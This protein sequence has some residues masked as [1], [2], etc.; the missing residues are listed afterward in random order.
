MTLATHIAAP[1]SLGSLEQDEGNTSQTHH[2]IKM[3]V[4]LIH[5]FKLSRV[6]AS[7]LCDKNGLFCGYSKLVAR[8]C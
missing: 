7:I 5:T 1:A 2:L 3:C 4:S 6:M 8:N